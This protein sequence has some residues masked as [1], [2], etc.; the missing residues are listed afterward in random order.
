MMSEG[1][2]VCDRAQVISGTPRKASP[3]PCGEMH[4]DLCCWRA[5]LANDQ[6]EITL[7]L[8]DFSTVTVQYKVTVS[9]SANTDPIAMGCSK[10]SSRD[11]AL[12]QQ[13]SGPRIM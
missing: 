7:R 1:S 11:V 13:R 10:K 4:G 3:K 5:R 12:S 6:R 8:R 9:Q 2:P